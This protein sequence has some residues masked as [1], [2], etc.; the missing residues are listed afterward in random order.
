MWGIAVVAGV[1]ALGACS[2][3]GGVPEAALDVR[4]GAIDTTVAIDASVP[5][6]RRVNVAGAA[7]TG[8]DHPGDWEADPGVGGMC[9]GTF[10]LGPPMASGTEDDG[11]YRELMFGNPLDCSLAM[12]PP[13]MYRVTLL[14]AEVFWGG[15]P[16]NGPTTG[17]R[18]FD[19]ELEG[20]RVMTDF[21]ETAEGGGCIGGPTGHPVDKVFTLAITDDT[22]DIHM[23]ATIDNATLSAIELVQQ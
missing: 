1:A 15:L 12:I 14:F 13:G 3:S 21:D 17:R 22:L 10:Y 18:V 4:D 5:Y 16:C 23:P 9:N 8:V 19:V 6:V 2:F 7:V 20:T 11:L